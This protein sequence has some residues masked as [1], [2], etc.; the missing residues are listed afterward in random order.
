M[1][2]TEKLNAL[3][4]G[5]SNAQGKVFERQAQPSLY[6]Q[7]LR[8]PRRVKLLAA[9]VGALVLYWLAGGT[10]FRSPIKHTKY[11]SVQTRVLGYGGRWPGYKKLKHLIIFGDS[12]TETAFN[13]EGQLPS[14][15]DPLG[16]PPDHAAWTSAN[17]PNW[18][19]F[20]P[21]TYN[22]SL[23]KTV[24]LAAGGA[25]LDQELIPQ[26]DP[27]VRSLRKQVELFNSKFGGWVPPKNFSWAA[28]DTLF[29]FWQGINDVH[30]TF[31]WSNKSEV[32]YKVL[33]Q[34]AIHVVCRHIYDDRPCL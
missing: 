27:N 7:A 14:A 23:L 26:H 8:A 15:E 2:E 11:T 13:P 16:N 22:Q 32:Q 18:A 12:Y 25:T 19:I 33:Q 1:E 9:I 29:I 10:F 24:N 5:S 34:Y 3:E 4:E 31:A 20:L 21:T 6:E 28:E 30:N 17:G